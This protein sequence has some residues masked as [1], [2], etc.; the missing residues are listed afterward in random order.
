MILLGELLP[1]ET[2]RQVALAER[3]SMSRIPVREALN[4]LEAEGVVTYVPRVGHAVARFNSAELSEIYLMR[5]LLEAQL[6]RTVDLAEVDVAHLVAL[7]DELTKLGE[8]ELWERKRLNREFHFHLF[9]LSPL[10]VVRR[11][12]ERLWNMSEFYR[13]LF[14]YDA[15]SRRWIVAQHRRI[16]AAV[17]AKDCDRLLAEIDAH[18]HSAEVAVS[19]RLGPP[20]HGEIKR[21][22]T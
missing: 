3:L 6:L 5:Q 20:S 13:S 2:L 22:T 8:T 18:R 9:S 19:A 7:N 16:I 1:G 21:P 17:R 4:Q 10:S 14:A 12:V 15:D 11:E